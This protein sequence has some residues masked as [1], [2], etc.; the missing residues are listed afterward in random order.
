L[1][2]V[3]EADT[4][5]D[6][7]STGSR[8]PGGYGAVISWKGKTQEIRGGECKTQKVRKVEKVEA[9]RRRQAGRR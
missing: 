4:Y 6:G 1:P 9:Y 7:A 2:K 3:P 5:T 8:G